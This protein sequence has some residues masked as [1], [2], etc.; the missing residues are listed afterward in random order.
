MSPYHV[1]LRIYHATGHVWNRC[2][3]HL[4]LSGARMWKRCVDGGGDT[5]FPRCVRDGMR[6]VSAFGGL[7][8]STA[9]EFLI[10]NGHS[11]LSIT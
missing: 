11:L 6:E 1:S 4:T 2:V 10:L 7:L 8:A 5:R 9:F 3:A